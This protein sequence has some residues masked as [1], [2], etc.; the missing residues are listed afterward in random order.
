M[1]KAGIIGGMDFFGSY[2]T[3]KFLLEDFLV[4]ALVPRLQNTPL[5]DFGLKSHR[6]IEICHF[7]LEDEFKMR[8]FINDCEIVVHCGTPIKLGIQPNGSPLY[9]PVI[10]KMGALLNVLRENTSVSK[11]ILLA[12][13]AALSFSGSLQ[14]SAMH[15]KKENKKNKKINPVY[16]QARF[17]AEK[18]SHTIHSPDTRLEIVIVPPVQLNGNSLTNSKESTVAGLRFIF[19]TS[20]RHDPVFRKI[21]NQKVLHTIACADDLPDWIFSSLAETHHPY[22]PEIK[23]SKKPNHQ[24]F[25]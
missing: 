7:D 15:E 8:R 1:R 23:V 25:H 14:F 24:I 20:I 18:V 22:N 21:L 3:L 2:I 9:I 16:T 10:Q 19:G 6:N 4:K 17:H 11:V 12:S 5:I 13:A